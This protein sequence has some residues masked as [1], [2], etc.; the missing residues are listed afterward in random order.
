[1]DEVTCVNDVYMNVVSY[2]VIT[3]IKGITPFAL[4][5]DLEALLFTKLQ[6]LRSATLLCT[7]L[8]C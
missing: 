4:S 7:I 6:A 3:W 1:M 8:M 5:L 2:T